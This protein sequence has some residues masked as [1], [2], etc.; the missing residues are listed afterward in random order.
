MLDQF[1]G[2]L[3]EERRKQAESNRDRAG[4]W[5]SRLPSKEEKPADPESW[6]AVG[7][8]ANP[9]RQCKSLGGPWADDID[10]PK[11]ALTVHEPLKAG[12]NEVLLTCDGDPLVLEWEIGRGSWVLAIA[13]G[14]F[15]LNL[16]LVNP[17]AG[18]WPSASSIGSASSPGGLPS[19]KAPCC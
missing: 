5:V 10:A 7:R 6:F 17:C 12:E 8:A 1:G 15:L 9:P 16:P 2:S 14:S 3:D 11:A 18:G 19:S 4:G 13:N